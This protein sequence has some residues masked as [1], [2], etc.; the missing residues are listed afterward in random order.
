MLRKILKFCLFAFATLLLVCLA[1]YAVFVLKWQLWTLLFILLGISVAV[2]AGFFVRKL[3]VRRREKRFVDEVIQRDEL[4]L[5]T[6]SRKEQEESRELQLKWKEAVDTLKR[7]HLKKQGNP[8]YVLPWYM[9]LGESGSGKTTAIQSAR[10]SSPFAEAR[11]VS[12]ISGTRNCDWW[13]FENAIVIDTA[14][15]YAIPVDEGRDKGD[16]HEFLPMLA[17]Y[18]KKEPL[19]GLIITVAVDKLLMSSRETLLTDA[20]TL[21]SRIHETMVALGAKFP[22]YLLVTKCDLVQGMTQ[23]CEQLPESCLKQAMG[24][25]SEDLNQTPE[26][27][28]D[29]VAQN[30]DE[31]LRKLRML[32]LYALKTKAADPQLLLFPDEFGKL[33]EPLKIFAQ[34]VFQSN[35]YQETPLLRGVFFSSGAQ[36]GLAYSHFLKKLG[37]STAKDAARVTDKGLFLHDFFARVLPHD[38]NFFAPTQRVLEWQRTTRTLGLTAW[39]GLAVALGLFLCLAFYRNYQII[40]KVPRQFVQTPVLTGNFIG[41]LGVMQEFRESAVQLERLNAAWPWWSPRFGLDQSL[42]V[43]QHLKEK[44]TEQFKIDVLAPL[45]LGLSTRISELSAATRDATIADYVNHLVRR[46]LLLNEK[47]QEK[48]LTRTEQLLH[49]SFGIVLPAQQD[50]SNAA[51]MGGELTAQY[52]AYLQWSQNQKQLALEKNELMKLLQRVIEIRQNDLEWLVDWANQ[53]EDLS[54]VRLTDF[55]PT[56]KESQKSIEVRPAF[57]PGGKKR[58]EDFLANIQKSFPAGDLSFLD[59]PRKDFE[60]WYAQAYFQEWLAFIRKFPDGAK[61]TTSLSS[62]RL[63]NQAM[64]TAEGPYFALLDQLA[65][66]FEPYLDADELPTWARL[67]Y[68][69]QLLKLGYQTETAIDA[70]KSVSQG[71]LGKINLWGQKLAS[72]LTKTSFKAKDRPLTE[73]IYKKYRDALKE[74]L[75][76]TLSRTAA[77]Q[78]ASD[79]FR[80][81]ASTGQA[82]ALQAYRL[83]NEL[84]ILLAPEDKD[85]IAVIDI[86][87]GP[88]DFLW[89]FIRNETA[90]QLQDVWEKDVLAEIRGVRQE[91]VLRDIMMGPQG[92]ANNFVRGA[93]APFLSRNRSRGYYPVKALGEELQIEKGFFSYMNQSELAMRI[94]QDSYKV[95]LRAMPTSTNPEAQLKPRATYLTMTCDAGMFELANFN[96]PVQKSVNWS[97][98]TCGNVS[99]MIE[100]GDLLLTTT[101]TGDNAFSKFLNDF[102]QGHKKFTPADFPKENLV[103]KGMGFKY[104]DVRYDLSGHQQAAELIRLNPGPPPE[105]IAACWDR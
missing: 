38:R 36:Q 63:A 82:S 21:R 93:A 57:T 6:L 70:G 84:H 22:V 27:F 30:M 50:D 79:V 73:E 43:E 33:A 24:C 23:F 69:H 78:Q 100:V 88:L 61:G 58:I 10:V 8:L 5:K 102:L 37:L 20:Q 7:S 15:R 12:G 96:F 66:E 26:Q 28:T 51:A 19:N 11:K 92:V 52:I 71:I 75:S 65:V 13:F 64:V 67:V 56:L 3:L 44:Y 18:R 62:A 83:I 105:K 49:P 16:W 48:S 86:L 39:G 46:I 59:G 81:D 1:G 45:D 103:L 85:S 53:Q 74:L 40:S 14:G 42:E 91:R 29:R 9:V 89:S 98:T 80:Q 31:H 41:D 2:V 54:A 97:P 55:W 87:R 68:Y 104:I 101:Y 95:N 94:V 4:R 76:A 99:L 77:F 72:N 34:G 90:C 17:K 35:P 47:M 60:N 25:I 32:M